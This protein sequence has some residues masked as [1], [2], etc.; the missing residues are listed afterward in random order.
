MFA[1]GA[2]PRR[3]HDRVRGGAAGDAGF[4]LQGAPEFPLSTSV[5]PPLAP[6]ELILNPLAPLQPDP[7]VFKTVGGAKKNVK[8]TFLLFF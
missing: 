6:G 4:G 1:G 5:E 3:L 8:K 7:E 2:A